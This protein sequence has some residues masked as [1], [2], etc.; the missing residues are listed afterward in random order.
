MNGFLAGVEKRALRMAEQNNMDSVADPNTVDPSE[1]LARSQS[2][3]VLLAALA[4]LPLRQQQAFMLR[5]WEGLDVAQTAEAMACSQGSV[6]T[7]YSR[8]VHRLRKQ[9][10][11]HWP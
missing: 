9:M 6:K 1:H 8:A 7:H 11:G 10:E 5:V 4:T 2:G 3:K